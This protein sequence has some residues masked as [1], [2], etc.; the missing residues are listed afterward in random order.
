[1][2]VQEA[3]ELAWPPTLLADDV[4]DNVV[5]EG[6]AGSGCMCSV[7]GIIENLSLSFD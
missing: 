7:S 6:E 1:M 2:S 3:S 4:Q 5:E